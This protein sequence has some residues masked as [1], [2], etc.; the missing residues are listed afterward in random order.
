MRWTAARRPQERSV[1]ENTASAQ[2]I[3]T[4][5][6]ATDFIT[7]TDGVQT[8]EILTYSLGGADAASFSIDRTNGQLSTKAELDKETKDTYV[9]TVTATDPSGETDTVTVT[10]KVTNVDEAPEIMVGGLGDIGHG[11]S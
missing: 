9:V 1:D 3:G 11:K 10:I 2:N 7:A 5:V 4:P 6:T 8:P